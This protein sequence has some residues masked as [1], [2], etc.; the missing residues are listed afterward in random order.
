[1]LEKLLVV[2]RDAAPFYEYNYQSVVEE[3]RKNGG[4]Q[5]C[6]QSVQTKGNG[7]R[8]I[9]GRVWMRTSRKWCPL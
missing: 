3:C 6:D 8:L 5:I 7:Q 1:M 2:A 9:M 4:A